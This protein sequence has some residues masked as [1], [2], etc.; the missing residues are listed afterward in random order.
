MKNLLTFNVA[1]DEINLTF[2]KI[3]KG[4]DKTVG[5]PTETT[6]GQRRG[7]AQAEGLTP[8]PGAC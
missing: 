1:F 5:S 4:H 8:P 2:N 7:R 6:S 3:T